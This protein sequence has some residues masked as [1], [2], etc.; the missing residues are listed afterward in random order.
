[1]LAYLAWQRIL[2]PEYA[3]EVPFDIVNSPAADGGLD[4]VRTFH[5]PGRDRPLEDT[6]RVVD[7]QLH[8][9][10]GKR[11][12]FEVGIAEMTSSVDRVYRRFSVLQ[13]VGIH[14]SP[15]N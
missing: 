1:M 5:F 3:R 14:V 13:E 8:D 12:G 6:M 15:V 10:M 9:F 2:F 4:A 7:G 11:R